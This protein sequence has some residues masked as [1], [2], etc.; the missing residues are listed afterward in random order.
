MSKIHTLKWD[1]CTKEKEGLIKRYFWLPLRIQKGGTLFE[2]VLSL[3]F[4]M[5]RRTTNI[6][7][8]VSLIINYLDKSRVGGFDRYYTSILILSI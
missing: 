2:I 5:K 6:F 3:L 1:F 7:E 4:L 8:Y